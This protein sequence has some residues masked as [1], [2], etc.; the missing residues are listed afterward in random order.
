M[1][2][3]QGETALPTVPAEDRAGEGLPAGGIAQT[4]ARS[5]EE[6][7]ARLAGKGDAGATAL[8]GTG[9]L[10]SAQLHGADLSGMDL[11]GQDLSGADL[12]GAD[13]SRTRFAGACLRGAILQGA[14]LEKS[15]FLGADLTDADL[16]DARG[17][18]V[19]F[20]RADLSGALL[21]SARLP[22]AT[23]TQARLCRADLRAA[24]LRGA[25]ILEADLSEA[26]LSRAVL[27]DADL[28][29]S[30]VD[31]AVFL[32]ADL[33]EARLRGISGH[34][35]A[36]WI[37]TDIVGVDF[38]GAYLVRRTIED[39]NYL[40][41]FRT[42][43]RLNAGIYWVWWVTSDC[44]R[45]FLRWGLWTLMLMVLFA[46]VYETV[47]LDLGDHPT[48]LSSL[49]YSVVTLTT[50]GY[51]DVVPASPAAQIVAMSEVVVG[52]VMLG[53]LL[54]IFANKMARRAD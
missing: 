10:R 11:S 50:L 18:S 1:P 21:F 35:S 32:D 52:Y 44:G 37:G 45:S 34:H 46:A 7:A 19:G 13:L 51:G 54:S 26:D 22:G 8:A 27:R 47:K 31:R 25:R 15:E 43:S 23:L 30:R 38:C 6:V 2:E 12:S 53:G 33:R 16:S 5:R 48:V 29:K 4:P 14:H 40:H 20:G 39:Q 3:E 9:G 36:N 17:E 41:E 49:Y 28:E 24:N 42:Q